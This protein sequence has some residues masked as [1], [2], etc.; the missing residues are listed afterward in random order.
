MK[1]LY[2]TV[3]QYE[4]ILDP[5]QNKVM[6]RMTDVMIRKRIQEYC[7]Y[8]EQKYKRGE[9]WIATYRGL[10]ITKIDKDEKGWYVETDGLMDKCLLDYDK[11][12]SYYDYCLSNGQKIDKQKGFLIEDVGVYFRWRRHNGSL[13]VIDSPNFD[14]TQGLPE[15]L[16]M[17]HVARSCEKSKRLDVCNKIKSI[18]LNSI[19]EVKISGTGCKNIIIH[20]DYPCG[21]I[22][23]PNGVNIHH[24]K[25]YKEYFDLIGLR[26]Q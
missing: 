12:K 11:A 14:S 9:L 8:N 18:V 26:I 10:N 2:N 20:V 4:S 16:N 17:L 7:V 3:Q 23:V 15:E 25:T 21:N 6:S 5:D 22:T 1:T 13:E 19:D 24:P